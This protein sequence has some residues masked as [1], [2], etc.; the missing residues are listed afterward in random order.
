MDHVDAHEYAS[1]LLSVIHGRRPAE[2]SS[3]AESIL[4]AELT[5][6][7]QVACAHAARTFDRLW[8]LTRGT[9]EL[10]PGLP[11]KLF[12][13]VV[14]LLLGVLSDESVG[15][16][17][18]ELKATAIHWFVNCAKH[19]D[20]PRIVQMLSTMLMNPV[21]ARVSIQY[22]SVQ[23]R[24]T[25]SE[26]I[27]LFTADERHK[28]HHV[29]FDAEKRAAGTSTVWLPE[30]R[31]RLLASTQ[32]CD[33]SLDRSADIL[34][35]TRRPTQDPDIPNFD[36]D[37]DSISMDTL[38]LNIAHPGEGVDPDVV[39]CVQYLM[40]CVVDIEESELEIVKRF[41][42]AQES[43]RNEAVIFRAGLD[44]SLD[45]QS[46]SLD[47][48]LP[49]GRNMS[50][51]KRGHRRT[52]SLQESIFSCGPELKLLE[53]CEIVRP[54]QKQLSTE[55]GF[56]TDLS[57]FD[58]LHTHMLLYGE[59]GRLVD[60]SRCESAFRILTALLHPRGGPVLP[61][62]MLLNCLVSSGTS[63][64]D[65]TS[66]TAG[67]LVELMSRHVKAILGQQFWG[68]GTDEDGKSSSR[69]FT[70]L[71]LLLTIT[72]HF[73]RSYFLNSPIAPVSDDDLIRSW[74]CKMAALD[75]LTQLLSELG[76]MLR[77]QQNQGLVTFVQ[78]IIQRSKLQKC[79]LH[80][81]LT[82]V[83]DPRSSDSGSVPISVTIAE[84][85]EGR[86]AA[87]GKRQRIAGLL[88]SYN[89]S[90]LALTAATIRLEHDIKIGYREFTDESAGLVVN[91][92]PFTHSFS[93]SAHNRGTMR[94]S[95]APLVELKMFL[96]TVLS[97]IKHKPERH[98]AWLQF[99]VHILPWI[100]R[101]LSTFCTHVT[102]QLCKNIEV[103]AVAAFPDMEKTVSERSPS[104]AIGQSK[105]RYPANYLIT[106]FETLTTVI[107]FC[108][109][110]GSGSCTSSTLQDE[111]KVNR[112]STGS[113]HSATTGMVG[114]AMNAI[115]GIQQITS[116]FKT[117][118][119][120]DTSTTT[121]VPMAKADPR[122]VSWQEARKQVLGGLPHS[123][124]TLCD[125]WG[126]VRRG[127]TPILPIGS[128]ARLRRLIIELLNPIAQ[129]HQ[130]QYL[131]AMSLVWLTRSSIGAQRKTEPDV[132]SFFYSPAQLDVADLLLEVRT[133]PFETVLTVVA[134]S[135]KDP[136]GKAGKPSTATP[137]KSSFPTEAPLLE[138]IHGCLRGLNGE[139]TLSC[140]PPLNALF[141]E[142]SLTTLPPRA[143]FL[144][145][146]MLCD[147]VRIAGSLCI[148]EDRAV[149]RAVHD[150][151]Q[152]LT[153][154]INGIVGWQLETTTWLKRTLVVKSEPTPIGKIS[155]S[156]DASPMTE[157][158]S[159]GP[160]LEL[161]SSR[162]STMS[163]MQNRPASLDATTNMSGTTSSYA[164]ALTLQDSK[165][166][167][168]SLR[169]SLKIQ[170]TNN[171]KRDP[172]HS[173]QALF[174]LAENLPELIDSI[175]KSDD[176]E[177]LL[178]TLHSV[179]ANVV[180]YLKSK[181]ARYARFFLASSQLLANMSSYNYMRP[182]WKKVTL[183]L[184]LDSSFFRMDVHS[185]KQWLIVTDHLMTHD[186]TSFKELLKSISYTPSSLSL[187]QSREQ[188]YESRSQ[189]LKR[190]AFI[191]FGSE[192]DQ[193]HSQLPDIQE[194]LAENLR[195]CPH[196]PI[197][198]SVLLCYRVLLI[199]LRPHSLVSMWPAMVTELIHV[200]L[201]VEQQLSDDPA[202][203][204]KDEVSARDDQWMQL[205]LA[206]AKL[207]EALCTLPAGY[208][209]QFQ[210]CN[211]AFVSSIA[212]CGSSSVFMPFADRISRRLQHK[213]GALSEQDLGA[214]PATLSGMKLLTSFEELRPFFYALTM[215]GKTIGQSNQE[216]S[217][218]WR[219]TEALSGRL[220]H[221]ASIAR[222][223]Q[224]LYVDF[225]EHWQL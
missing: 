44:V 191:V 206:A 129:H 138:L 154:A 145:F 106:C 82:A 173:T 20:L 195:V 146:I 217:V 181:N 19:N 147:F 171:N 17:K 107:H 86:W 92:L 35:R 160:I 96:I 161:G 149:G 204:F 139:Q 13:R 63:T 205:F 70:L 65:N 163:L 200:L 144:Q 99:V 8:T 36:D 170:D 77:A 74:K 182:V 185:I 25:Q 222:L 202:D 83:H 219:D 93:V 134:D 124:A 201:Q 164:S 172:A 111:S 85:N 183:E 165:K 60:L 190:L 179:W 120:S 11:Q 122:S 45:S 87:E 197:R 176:K 168:S 27:S 10:L 216:K 95:Q 52:D 104:E 141:N 42:E 22:V 7:D 57:L 50:R 28:M 143:I 80:L 208:I 51:L 155:Q 23:E 192:V 112:T 140:W 177:R 34:N 218:F 130:N 30:L 125:I 100:D 101:S 221:S 49:N 81:L 14:M 142:S 58:E 220:G 69:H 212:S 47:E 3:E 209:A 117:I 194:R 166:S 79:L 126:V 132:A 128:T 18:T 21:T 38:S 12:S 91:R 98:E 64:L 188:E 4:L 43:E 157:T 29:V 72:L 54:A 174:L 94:D 26:A 90:L 75:F 33:T 24:V 203:G 68:T 224:A 102:E 223:E 127:K 119:F 136:S 175:C 207:L 5:Q 167:N 115:P 150:S 103:A 109:V 116:I 53:Q 225:A 37:T 148:V 46:T 215:H 213:Y 39:D 156:V 184:L 214:I 113:G 78:S 67:S 162:G 31:A 158:V 135:L 59:S 89:S 189:A 133:L 114:Q 40:D 105:S 108:V 153:E 198:A 169:N 97:A 110:G 210:M 187:M 2:P 123:L 88:S 71:E 32:E 159:S 16:E 61:P 211:W 84:F 152:R 76:E 1:R 62:R 6:P 178:P 186:K 48:K 66:P 180:P 199:R 56:E 15:S 9:D 41:Q 73:L 137:D 196:P 131:Q 193:Y 121:G 151:C 118:T 55:D